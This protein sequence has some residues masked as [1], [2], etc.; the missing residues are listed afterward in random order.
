MPWLTVLVILLTCQEVQPQT[1]KKCC[2]LGLSLDLWYN[3]HRSQGDD[4]F[5]EVLRSYEDHTSTRLDYSVSPLTSCPLNQRKEF[6][7][8]SIPEEEGDL[9]DLLYVI[10]N[11]SLVELDESTMSESVMKTQYECVDLAEDHGVLV[12]VVCQPQ[13]AGQSGGDSFI[14]KCCPPTQSLSPQLNCVE[15]A[16][17]PPPPRSVLSSTTLRPT[18]LF[19]L[20]TLQ[21]SDWCGGGLLVLD[22]VSNIITDGRVVSQNSGN[23]ETYTCLDTVNSSLVAVLCLSLKCE[24]PGGQCVSKCCPL[25]EMLDSQHSC[26]PVS[27]ERRRTDLWRHPQPGATS[28]TSYHHNFMNVFRYPVSRGYRIPDC[29]SV[30]AMEPNDT[31]T[32]LLNNSLHHA[33]YGVTSHYC[34]D[35]ARDEAGNTAEMVMKCVSNGT[36]VIRNI[37][38]L[39]ME[40]N[41]CLGSHVFTIRL[42][43]TIS[44]VISCVFLIITFLVYV[45]V[46]ELNNLHG[47]IVLSN[48]VSIFFLTSYLVLVYNGSQLLPPTLCKIS[49]CQHFQDKIK[50]KCSP[51]S[52]ISTPQ[53]LYLIH[54]ISEC[55]L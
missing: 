25:A 22:T 55:Y 41:S 18:A 13:Q 35:N 7:V 26:V 34:V 48:V 24:D 29:L 49:G 11:D 12:A 17:V 44:G 4:K 20:R 43:N 9:V 16:P 45:W 50:M 10:V 40:E 19:T 39:V 5:A 2:P 1:V 36:E 28:V 23:T 37:S 15:E 21:S 46:P 38:F 14:T 8:L 3:C 31:Y 54:T 53:L 6:E 27:Q 52:F 32:V 30:V 42:V 47:K 51:P 33:D